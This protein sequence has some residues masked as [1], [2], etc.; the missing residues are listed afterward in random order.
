MFHFKIAVVLFMIAW[1][2]F[3][4]ENELHCSALFVLCYFIQVLLS[5][6][7]SAIRELFTHARQHI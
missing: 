1:F 4:F 7:S 5:G 6:V 2:F 3:H